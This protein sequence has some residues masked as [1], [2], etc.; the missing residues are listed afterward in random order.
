[1][2]V[3]AAVLLLLGFAAL[4][5]FLV[6]KAESAGEGTWSRFVYLFGAAE[7]LVFTA[8]GWLFGRE[9]H[10]QAAQNA[11]VRA[12]QA[13]TRAESAIN[14]AADQ[15]AKGRALKA[16]VEARARLL[17]GQSGVEERGIGTD[18][19]PADDVRQLAEFART[20]FPNR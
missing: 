7:A 18:E 6:G 15:E 20:L 16:A 5:F 19:P 8:V 11:E 2:A 14:V 3:V 17:P 9:V 10:R 13:T 4:V 1:M 12:D